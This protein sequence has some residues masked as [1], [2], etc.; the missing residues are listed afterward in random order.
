MTTDLK[1][2]EYYGIFTTEEFYPEVIG[3]HLNASSVHLQYLYPK[4]AVWFSAGFN[5]ILTDK[6]LTFPNAPR[7]ELC[8]MSGEQGWGG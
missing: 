5:L 1:T 6:N 7:P 4:G 2:L 8:P 3:K